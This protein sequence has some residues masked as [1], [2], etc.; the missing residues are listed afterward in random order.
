ME[1]D[2]LIVHHKTPHR[3]DLSLFYDA[4]NLM[5]VCKACHD[6]P[7]RAEEAGKAETGLDGWPVAQA[8]PG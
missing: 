6:G 3:G 2:A 8:P 4:D 7:I 5:V 1:D